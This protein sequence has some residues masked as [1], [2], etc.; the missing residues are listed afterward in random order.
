MEYRNNEIRRALFGRVVFPDFPCS[1]QYR[2]HYAGGLEVKQPRVPSCVSKDRPWCMRSRFARWTLPLRCGLQGQEATNAQMCFFPIRAVKLYSAVSLFLYPS[3]EEENTRGPSLSSVYRNNTSLP[4]II[5]YHSSCFFI[6]GWHNMT[7]K[8]PDNH[9]CTVIDLKFTC[10]I[11]IIVYFYSQRPV[12]SLG[13]GAS[14]TY[15]LPT[16]IQ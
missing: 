6:S 2:Q 16:C 15:N 7:Q 10:P 14:P 4:L 13:T 11:G 5:K 12:A 8:D 3:M 9:R 1:T